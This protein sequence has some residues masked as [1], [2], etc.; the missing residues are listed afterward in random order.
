M[1]KIRKRKSEI[2]KGNVRRIPHVEPIEVE[3]QDFNYFFT[4]EKSI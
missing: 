4:S 3:V 1:N 2:K